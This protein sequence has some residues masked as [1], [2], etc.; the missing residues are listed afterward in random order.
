MFLGYNTNGFAHHRLTDA[1]AIL[2]ELGYHGIAITPDFHSLGDATDPAFPQHLEQVHELLQKQK[3]RC[4]IETGARFILDPRRKHQP[5][6]LSQDAS[7]REQR[8]SFLR[9][10]TKMALTLE[11]DAV[12][13]WSGSA[14]SN[15]PRDV[16][17]ARLVEECQ[18]LADSAPTMRFAFEPEPGMFISTMPAF[19]ELHEKVNRPNFGLTLDVGHLVCENEL[20]IR[21]HIENWQK[22]LWNVHIEDMR[23]GVH[24]HLMFGEG[25][26]DF[27]D[28]FAGL[29]AIDY[30]LGV[31]VELSRHSY[32]AMRTAQRSELFLR[33]YLEK[34]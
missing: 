20:P 12:S 9:F 4:V 11:A 15:E 31:Y 19:A 21:H 14:T 16:L 24:D 28:I 25:D 6:L 27:A 1:I 13:F 7:E 26:V 30:R 29:Q 33:E 17:M 22:W 10:A 32:D 5:T 2:A 8:A 18:Q 34:P 3:L 23:K